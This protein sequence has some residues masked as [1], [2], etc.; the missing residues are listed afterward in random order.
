MSAV[1]RLFL[2]LPIS[3]KLV[4]LLWLFVLLV[5]GLLGLS[6]FTIENLSAVRA[7]VGGEG[8]WSK[9]EKQA[10]RDLS[11][12]SISH[13]EQDYQNFRRALLVPLGDRKGRLELEKPSPDLNVVRQ[14]FLEGRLH[15]D[16][17]DSQIRLFREFRRSKHMAEAVETWAEG[18]LLIAQLE[19]LGT[20][21]HSEIS[22]NKP[23]PRRITQLAR[24]VDDIDGQLTPLEDRFSSE[25]GAAAR[26]AKN[27]FL[28]I[29]FAATGASLVAGF[30]FTFFLSRHARQNEERYRHLINTANDAIVEL[31]SDT[32]TILEANEQSAK[33]LGLKLRQIVGLQAEQLVDEGDQDEYRNWLRTAATG[34]AVS[35]KQLHVLR[36]DG[37]SVAVEVNASLTEFEGKKIVQ[38]IFRDITERQ[39]LEQE[40]RQA[41]KMEVIG[42]LAGGIAH[43]F[44]NLLMVIITQISKLSGTSSPEQISRCSE[45]IRSAAEKAASLTKQLLAFGRKQ[46]LDIEVLD[47]NDLLREV[48]EMLTTL[49]SGRVKRTTVLN[50]EPLPV[51]VDA[52]KIEQ[53]IMNLAVNAID[54]MPSGGR[55]TIKTSRIWKVRDAATNSRRPY[56][57]LEIIDTGYGMDETTKAH[58]F[59]PFFT[60]KASGKGTGLGLATVYGIVK[61][62][63]GF[64]EVESELGK[65]ATFRVFLPIAGKRATTRRVPAGRSSLLKGSETVL[66]AED[67]DSI[68]AELREALEMNGYRVLNAS[69]GRE[70]SSLAEGHSGNIDV[71]VTDIVMPEIRGLDLAK[72]VRELYPHVCVIFMSGYSEEIL[73]ENR[74]GEKRMT[75]LQKPF[76]PEDLLRKI[77]ECLSARPQL[78]R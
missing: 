54:A 73:I 7:Y 45:T 70:A 16:D 24:K 2:D 56:A 15:P 63:D 18:D 25:L 23:D 14:G 22:S 27:I 75:L 62:S 9:A 43:D 10:A 35:G 13:S 67:Q 77:R 30:L 11:R 37:R 49:V 71:L 66:L 12:Y 44:N 72:R 74:L 29:T 26:E 42:R 32:G 31:D 3:R 6:Y 20:R 17:V 33:L 4:I 39:R 59:E 46:V 78:S 76:E 61:Q 57:L 8:L 5:I 60:T 51:R 40:V 21:L 28:L 48:S 64:I 19:D 36:S 1:R 52:G 47:L 53:V 69:D 58:L 65:G 41:Q 55:L 68:R 34:A 50:I 38:G